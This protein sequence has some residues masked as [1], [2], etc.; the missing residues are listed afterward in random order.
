[1]LSRLNHLFLLYRTKKR[2][3]KE[4]S[5]NY[6]TIKNIIN[7]KIVSVGEG[8]YGLID[9]SSWNSK[10]EKLVIGNFCSIASGVKFL[11]GGEH[12]YNHLTTYPFKA[13]IGTEIEAFSKG[14]ITIEDFV[15]IGTNALIL[16]GVKIGVGAIVGAGSVVTK[17]VPPFAI[18]AGNPAR[19]IKYRF[20]DSELEILSKLDLYYMYK[21]G[22][23]DMSDFYMETSIENLNKLLE[24][25]LEYKSNV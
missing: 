2:W 20:R 21:N 22:L 12:K 18:V 5:K 8:T 16:S 1:M 15:W 9:A 17:E 13:K 3:R 14:Q 7:F 25:Y 24:I 19:I 4:N 23:I 11:L 6:T 10:D